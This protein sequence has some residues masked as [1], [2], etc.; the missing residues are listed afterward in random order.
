VLPITW[1]RWHTHLYPSQLKLVLDLATPGMQ[2]WV[3]LIGWFTYRGNIPAQ[4]Q[5]PIPVLTRLNVWRVHVTNDATTT[6]KPPTSIMYLIHVMYYVMYYAAN[7][8]FHP[9]WVNKWE[10]SWNRM[11][12]T[13]YGWHSWHYLVKAMEVTAGLAESNGRILSGLWHVSLHV[14]CRLTTCTPGSAP[15][16]TLGNEYGTTL[17]LCGSAYGEYDWMSSAS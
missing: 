7:S 3:D 10:V 1:Q 8:A 9:F 13:V 11:C 16:L 14:T 2:S 15:G 6:A 5:A 4:R 12:A 17:P